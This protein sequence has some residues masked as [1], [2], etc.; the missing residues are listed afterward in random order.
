MKRPP[1]MRGSDSSLNT[2]IEHIQ[3]EIQGINTLSA[4]EEFM[5]HCPYEMLTSPFKWNNKLKNKFPSIKKFKE[6]IIGKNLLIGHLKKIYMTDPTIPDYFIKSWG[7]L[8]TELID[9][10]EELE[11]EDIKET[12]GT[13]TE[14]LGPI[15]M[16]CYIFFRNEPELDEVL[17]SLYEKISTLTEEE[18]KEAK[19]KEAIYNFKVFLN[20]KEGEGE[21]DDDESETADEFMLRVAELPAKERKKEIRK[22]SKKW[23]AALEDVIEDLVDVPKKKRAV[24]LEKFKEEKRIVPVRQD[25]VDSDKH[26]SKDSESK[27]PDEI[28]FGLFDHV[29]DLVNYL[30]NK[31]T[32]ADKEESL[33]KV[34]DEI[35]SLEKRTQNVEKFNS[36]MQED[37]EFL[38]D[39]VNHTTKNLVSSEKTYTELKNDIQLL[40]DEVKKISSEVSDLKY[41]AFMLNTVKLMEKRLEKFAGR[42]DDLEKVVRRDDENGQVDDGTQKVDKI[43]STEPVK[44]NLQDSRKKKAEKRDNQFKPLPQGK[45]GEMFNW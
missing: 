21:D 9:H 7:K 6:N 43:E 27:N 26:T 15:S 44:I 13:L 39:N 33:K 14:Q 4:A 30:E 18:I 28:L 34:K 19:E 36:K 25:G 40:S 24:L 32:P 5:K 1:G 37:V 2:P 8:Y 42:L 11:I 35:V 38:I 3:H 41:M 31:T 17:V 22:A 29:K 12:I 23:A 20:T 16:Y 10:L 45:L